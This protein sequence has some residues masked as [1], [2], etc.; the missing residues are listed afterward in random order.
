LVI[1]RAYQVNLVSREFVQSVLQ[2]PTAT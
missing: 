2:D 1:A